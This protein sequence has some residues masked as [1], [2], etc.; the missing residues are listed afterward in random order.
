MSTVLFRRP[1]RRRGPDMPEGE[2]SLQEPPTLPEAEPNTS[3]M[4]TYL[5][6]GLTSLAMLMM[7]LRPNQATAFSYIAIGLMLLSSVVMILAQV[8]RSAS[9]RK[10]KLKGDRR[11]YLRYLTQMRR[12]IR[13]TVAEQQKALAWRHPEPAALW[14]L[15][16]TSRQW[17]RRASDEDFSEVRVAVGEQKLALRL[18]PLATR[19]V[20]DLEPLSAHAL[21]S[22]IRAYGTVPEQ[23]IALYLRA[24]SRVLVTGDEER[25]RALVRAM[26]AQLAAFHAP[27]ELNVALCVSD[28][29]RAAW[30]WLKWL[31]H[32]QHGYQRDGAGQAR[33]AAADF[34]SLEELLG[35]D[36]TQR[37]PFDPDT[38][39]GR[40]EPF[41]VVVVDGGSVPGGHRVTGVGY[42]NTVL[43]DL[44]GALEWKS[45]RGTL[46]LRLDEE[47]L[48]LVRTDRDR[49][50]QSTLL[51]EPDALGPVAAQTL[52]RRLSPYRLG[53]GV[54]AS[55]PFVTETELTALLGIGDLRRHEPARLWRFP[56]EGRGRLRVPIA[57]GEDGTPVELDIKES[58][59]GG[60]GP[61]GMLIGATGSGKSELLRTLVL[62]LALTHS[63]ETLNFVLVDFKGGATFL[64]MD[65]LP[66]TS[67]VI[68]NL[69][70][71]VALVGRM[72]DALHGELV[73]R[74]ELLRKAGNYASVL[75]YERARASGTPLAPLPS[76]FVVVDEFSEL[77]AAHRD[78]ME[79]FVMIGRLGRSLGV[80]LLLASQRLEEGRMSQLEGHLSY[81][82]GLR[83]FSA[84]ESRGVLGVPDAYHLPSQPGSGY[85]KSGV[86]ALTR[87][88]AAYVS[89]AYKAPRR[90]SA[91]QA[92]IARQ[93]VPWGTE[94][95][96]PRV[97]PAAPDPEPEPEAE[98][99]EEESLL[100]LA[101]EKLRGSGPPAHQVWLPPLDAPP[102][103]DTLLPPL[104]PHP[105]LG[106]T[107]AD[108]PD[109][110]R[111]RVPV[112]LVD[113]PFEQVR[114]LL[115]VDLSGAGGHLAVAGGPQSGK[116][117]VL[118]TLICALALTHSPRETQ[119]YCLDFGGG[120]LS[121]LAGLPHVGGVSGRLDRE[122]IARTL[123]EVT[124]LLN[125]RELFFQEQGIDSMSTF[126]RRRARGEFPDSP[127][128]DV[129]LVV[130]GWSTVRSDMAD[131]L[132]HFQAIASRGLNYGVHLVIST[133]RWVEVPSWLRD[134]IGNKLE[135]RMGDP[136]DSS[137]DVR[138]AATVPVS[139]GRGLNSDK[140]HFLAALP[141]IDGQEQAE[142]LAD[143][144]A[145][146]V[147]AVAD[148]WDAPAAPPV[149]MLPTRLAAA[150][151]PEGPDPLRI[152][153]GL[154]QAE[155]EP[156]RHDFTQSPH[157]YLVGDTESGKT[158]ALRLIAQRIM[159]RH[160][161]DEA[162]FLVADFRRELIAAIPEEYRLGHAVSSDPLR[163]YVGGVARAMAERTP[164]ADISPARMRRAD[165]WEGPRLFVL[166][167]D[168]E[169]VGS[170]FDSPF[171]PLLT[172][173][174]LGYEVGL[175][176]VVARAS[177][178]AGRQDPL[179]RK[180]QEVNTSVLLLSCPPSEGQVV[181]GVR[182]RI[183]PPGRAQSVV[184]RKPGMMQLALPDEV[185]EEPGADGE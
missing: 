160:T 73:R 80:H 135:L 32:A 31:P 8:I 85:L 68:T 48:H 92:Q 7:F 81:R 70:D 152:T 125:R 34:Q 178:G 113:R 117:T 98:S 55:E 110:G 109:R 163:E 88:R 151:L 15:G 118:R 63:S 170:G 82:I 1:A 166:V 36:F 127:F 84:I 58:A 167:D 3:A 137:V 16:G 47:G 139:P 124:S 6:M 116:S 149:R 156:V 183:M 56:V 12:K 153:I 106:L 78:F 72:Q 185:P 33:L 79:L 168:Y 13:A 40:E 95:V 96:V 67:A 49:K 91:R 141:R 86:E 102:A 128:G 24:W 126:R 5:P 122:R 9:E 111:L 77:L 21:R 45:G 14:A 20:E 184:R 18:A 42:R 101:L 37:S 90:G 162:R 50:E 173:L 97:L 169:L 108:W 119:F 104:T 62:G 144:I 94:W 123:A 93:V 27:E 134:Q 140:M 46:R 180:L 142:D 19:P 41:T 25:A 53:G 66:H 159:A 39:P 11:D 51:G 161:P 74:Q 133:S 65:E 148:H 181:D 172:H 177:S 44:T 52:A 112:G 59:Q 38:P 157:L 146:L 10:R 23:P 61:H 164:G 22:F 105:D 158:S 35:A 26:L 99:S 121:S 29:R 130:D 71:E 114:D 54:T 147:E 138:K 4:W 103:L 87:F 107:A 76:L 179:V 89:G 115:T 136:M 145:D 154:D 155:L 182:S 28:E 83:T 30:E 165:W 129:F 150:D 132:E 69:A 143:A 60:M 57:V 174:P 120:A 176:V 43:V 131:D 2:L 75:E 17:E 100:G 175:H 64:G 171:E